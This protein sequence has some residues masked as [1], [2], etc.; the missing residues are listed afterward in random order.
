MQQLVA[1]GISEAHAI[2]NHMMGYVPDLHT[3]WVGTSDQQLMALSHEFPG[4]HRYA[5][6][7]EKASE[8]ERSKASRTYE[9]VGRDSCKK[10]PTW[11]E[12]SDLL[13][14]QVADQPAR[15]TGQH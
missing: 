5:L 14:H 7:M 3:I 4:F 6:I 13:P 10:Q 1:Q 9:R 8:A 11:V 12:S 15:R 2:I